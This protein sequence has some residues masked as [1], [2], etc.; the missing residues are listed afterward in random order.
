MDPSV[1]ENFIG[2]AACTHRLSLQFSSFG[3]CQNSSVQCFGIATE[4]QMLCA[5][6]VCPKL[7]PVFVLWSKI[8]RVPS[9]L[10][11][12]TEPMEDHS[13]GLIEIYTMVLKLRSQR[14]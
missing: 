4:S 5:R 7:F 9:D 6:S 3:L 1:A 2:R 11:V 12:P 10:L 8:K 13:K 14:E